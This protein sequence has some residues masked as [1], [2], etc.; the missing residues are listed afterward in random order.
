VILTI[1]NI[2]S[3]HPPLKLQQHLH[4]AVRKQ[5]RRWVAADVQTKQNK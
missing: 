1:R 2:R 5:E 3:A 4:A